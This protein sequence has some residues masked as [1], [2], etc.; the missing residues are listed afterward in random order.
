M[1]EFMRVY[2]AIAAVLA[3]SSMTGR[4]A[5]AP[6]PDS[7]PI[8]V[9]VPATA[10]APSSDD[11]KVVCKT[12]AVTGTRFGSQIC[13]TKHEW[14]VEAQAARDFTNRA[15]SGPCTGASCGH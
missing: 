6:N 4:V 10:T 5:A 14:A 12:I 13:H 3:L 2:L 15:T 7:A 9:G 8:S 11:E 1:G